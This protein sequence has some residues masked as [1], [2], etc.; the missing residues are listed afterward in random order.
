[1]VSQAQHLAELNRDLETQRLLYS[2][3]RRCH[4]LEEL[5]TVEPLP[6]I[7][8]PAPSKSVDASSDSDLGRWAVPF[9][10]HWTPETGMRRTRSV[11]EIDGQAIRWKSGNVVKM[12]PQGEHGI[13]IEG[14]DGRF[15]HGEIDASGKLL[16]DDG[17]RVWV[18]T[19]MTT[20]RTQPCKVCYGIGIR[21]YFSGDKEK[22]KCLYCLGTG[23]RRPFLG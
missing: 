5:P 3:G 19:H 16:W 10:G 17:K 22:V 15:H 14:K 4:I 12:E 11:I 7:Q 18:R 6:P 23:K 8:R 1:M 20:G 9:K 2:R 21:N 13:R